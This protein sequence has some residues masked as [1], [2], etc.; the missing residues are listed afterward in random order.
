MMNQ[1]LE[2][3][4]IPIESVRSDY[5]LAISPV[6]LGLGEAMFEDLNL[7]ALGYTVVESTATDLAMHVRLAHRVGE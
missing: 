6:V 1:T 3:R 5:A 4:G 2:P 7:P